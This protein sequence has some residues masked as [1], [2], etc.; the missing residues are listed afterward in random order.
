MKITAAVSA[1][2]L[3]ALRVADDWWQ[4]AICWSLVASIGAN[5]LYLPLA[6]G[7]PASTGDLAALFASAT[8]LLATHVV[9]RAWKSISGSDS[10]AS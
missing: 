10:N 4:L 1:A 3:L 8:G 6:K 7:V 9:V 5:I 2:Y